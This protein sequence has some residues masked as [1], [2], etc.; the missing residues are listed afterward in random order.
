MNDQKAYDE[1]FKDYNNAYAKTIEYWQPFYDRLK[2]LANNNEKKMPDFGRYDTCRAIFNVRNKKY[3]LVRDNYG[4]LYIC[5]KILF[6]KSKIIEFCA[7]EHGQN[8]LIKVDLN[9]KYPDYIAVL[10][11]INKDIDVQQTELLIEKTVKYQE[12]AQKEKEKIL[13]LV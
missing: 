11:A 3:Y 7:T 2:S 8:A 10:A 6:K 13:C 1:S 4:D 5:S 9:N 12:L